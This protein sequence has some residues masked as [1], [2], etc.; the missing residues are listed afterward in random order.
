MQKA[1]SMKQKAFTLIEVL[2]VVGIIG[3]L[4]SMGVASYTRALKNGRDARRKSDM[5]DVAAALEQYWAENDGTLPT[6][7]FDT[8]VDNL[9]KDGYLKVKVKPIGDST[10]QYY[11]KSFTDQGAHAMTFALCSKVELASNAN[12]MN[13]NCQ[14]SSI[15]SAE[16]CELK[17]ADQLDKKIKDDP[18][19]W[20]YCVKGV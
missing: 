8:I 5:R 6:G 3:I 10:Y 11:Y 14:G 15:K 2:V 18:K 20:Y 9:K 17:A 7:T 1:K 19:Q 4:A 16:S 12:S 13:T